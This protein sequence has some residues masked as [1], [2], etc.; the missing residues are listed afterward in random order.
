MF[1]LNR[2]T[3]HLLYTGFCGVRISLGLMEP[4]L[5][6]SI[7]RLFS[8]SLYSSSLLIYMPEEAIILPPM[9]WKW[10]TWQHCMWCSYL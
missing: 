9:K 3:M 8:A 7:L 2:K 1:D 6:M 5:I 10:L 4:R